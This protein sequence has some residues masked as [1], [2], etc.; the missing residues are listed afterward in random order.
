[1]HQ[2][3]NLTTRAPETLLICVSRWA[4]SVPWSAKEERGSCEGGER[5][6]G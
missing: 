4:I 5:A 3:E 6:R 2:E 1:M